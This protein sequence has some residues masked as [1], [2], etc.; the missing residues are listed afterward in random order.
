MAAHN[1]E[2]LRHE[3][4]ILSV[5]RSDRASSVNSDSSDEDAFGDFLKN[6][7]T[8]GKVKT[9]PTSPSQSTPR[10]PTSDDSVSEKTEICGFN[11]RGKCSYGNKCNALHTSEYLQT[12]IYSHF[13]EASQLHELEVLHR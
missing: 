2:G 4:Q 9:T 5:L 8:G 7:A 11:L 13:M 10:S 1:L 3:R 12:Q 6:L